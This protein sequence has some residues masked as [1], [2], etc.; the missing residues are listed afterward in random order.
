MKLVTRLWIDAAYEATELLNQVAD[1]LMNTDLAFMPFVLV[2]D[3]SSYWPRAR[4]G[5]RVSARARQIEICADLMG[6]SGL[7]RDIAFLAV[8]HLKT[9]ESFR[10]LRYVHQRERIVRFSICKLRLPRLDKCK[11]TIG[12]TAIRSNLPDLRWTHLTVQGDPLGLHLATHNR[13]LRSTNYD[14]SHT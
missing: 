4:C 14:F 3:T 5:P 10:I 9:K 7:H 2:S 12:S 6:Y 1:P 8:E 11:L 13:A